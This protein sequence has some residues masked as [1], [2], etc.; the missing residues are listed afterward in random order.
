MDGFTQSLCYIFNP[1]IIQDGEL[2]YVAEV[3]KKKKIKITLKG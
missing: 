2:H 1:S 3:F